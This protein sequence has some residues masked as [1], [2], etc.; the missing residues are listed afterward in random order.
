MTALSAKPS[1]TAICLMWAAAL[2]AIAAFVVYKLHDLREPFA[3]GHARWADAYTY[4]F[5][6]AHLDFGLAT[7][8]GLNVEGVTGSGEPIFYL[9][10]PPLGGLMQA[11]AVFSLGGDFWT[12]RV[13]PLLFNL[14][15]CGLIGIF[16]YRQRG[17][18][19]AALAILLFLG[20]PFVIKYGASNEG[21]QIYAIAAGLAGY[22]IYLRFLASNRW[23][24]LI[25]SLGCFGLGLAF[26]WL[27]G[28]MALTLLLHLLL[29]PLSMRVK[30][31]A[32]LLAG[33]MLGGVALILLVQ[34]GIATGEFLYPLRRALERSSAPQGELVPLDALIERQLSRYWNYF[35][36][37]VAILNMYWLLRR[38]LP[39]PNW[40]ASD[41]W[42]ILMWLPGLVYGF[43]LRHAAYNH[44]FLML[45]FMP[46]VTFMAALGMLNMMSDLNKTT[47][48]WIEGRQLA[49]LAVALLLGMHA[50]GAVRSAQNFERQETWDLDQGG[51]RV[52]LHLQALPTSSVLAADGSAHMATRIDAVTGK[53]YASIHP[54]FDYLM[55]R[56]VRAVDDIQA[57]HD[58]LC[59]GEQ[60]DRPVILLQTGTSG[61]QVLV[62]EEWVAQLYGF[63][64][65]VVLHLRLPPAAMCRLGT[66]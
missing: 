8:L 20:M 4:L 58:L 48:Q 38:L 37:V 54:Y 41:T 57:L 10:A 33:A 47:V 49:G 25:V 27:A 24:L 40:G 19:A 35:G 26:N 29:Q 12:V 64:R 23:K 43:L 52:A 63:D 18:L 28:F 65:V 14:I 30:G 31:M 45:G 17:A 2:A 6:R 44:D 39:K 53:E 21:H 32:T 36:P 16:A 60:T 42:A 13:L 3:F 66:G 5:A 11:V 7:T 34:Q 59:E 56:P 62:P 22:L 50:V 9:S 55:R 1:N 51:A 46:G 61:R 15:T